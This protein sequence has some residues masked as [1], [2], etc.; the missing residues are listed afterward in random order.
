[1]L[2]MLH[3][4]KSMLETITRV[5]RCGSPTADRSTVLVNASDRSSTSLI[6]GDVSSVYTATGLRRAVRDVMNTW[7]RTAVLA[8]MRTP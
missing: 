8:S 2:S 3:W 5:R 6:N 7:C 1:M 4:A